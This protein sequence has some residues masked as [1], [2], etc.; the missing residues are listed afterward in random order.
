MG[1]P[2]LATPNRFYTRSHTEYFRRAVSVEIF[3]P[4]IPAIRLPEGCAGFRR[5]F[6]LAATDRQVALATAG[7]HSKRNAERFGVAGGIG[8]AARPRRNQNDT[9]LY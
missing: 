6:F 4:A 2:F 8:Q 5:L 9:G 1:A 7:N 3:R